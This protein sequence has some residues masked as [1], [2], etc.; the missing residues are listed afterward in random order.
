MRATYACVG[1]WLIHTGFHGDSACHAPSFGAL[2]AS[3]LLSDQV[4]LLVVAQSNAWGGGILFATS[5]LLVTN[6]TQSILLLG[7]L[8][9]VL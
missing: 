7:K 6:L 4:G 2:I 1:V 9:W 8:L 5:Q 3:S